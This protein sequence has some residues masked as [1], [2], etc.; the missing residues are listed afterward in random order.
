MTTAE[1]VR[2]F[3]GRSLADILPL[4]EAILGRRI[5]DDF[6]RYYG[7]LLLERLR[8]D[9]KPIA[10]VK[11]AIAALRCPYCVAS[12][13]SLERVRLSLEITQL[14]SLFGSDIFSATQV[15]H[16]KPA[17]DLYLFVAKT[18]AVP[19]ERCVVIEDSAPGVSAGRAAGMSVIG[20]AGAAHATGD[21]ARHLAAAGANPVISLMTELPSAI[22]D[23]MSGPKGRQQLT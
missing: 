19:P 4:V 15:A 16:G 9:L 20:F 21:T 8:R 11:E 14:G 12:S 1:S 17:P 23:V 6:G 10:G 5:P 18:L 22:R 3:A 2:I 7:N 13:S